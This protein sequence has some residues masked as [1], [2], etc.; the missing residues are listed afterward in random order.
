M[1][2]KPRAKGVVLVLVATEVVGVLVAITTNVASGDLPTSWHAHLWLAWPAL[3]AL[4]LIGILLAIVLH[5]SDDDTDRWFFSK[6]AT[7]SRR[8]LCLTVRKTWVDDFL[9]HSL[10]RQAAIELGL[11]NRSDKLSY[12]WELYVESPGQHPCPLEPGISVTKLMRENCGLLILGEPG[13]GKTTLLLGLLEELLA[14]AEQDEDEIERIPV[15]FKLETWTFS[16]KPLA[17]WLVDE[18]S[19]DQYGVDRYVAERWIAEDQV[20]PLLDGLDEVALD[21]RIACARAIGFFHAAHRSVPLAVTSRIAD[22]DALGLRLALGAAILIRPLTRRQVSEYLDLWGEQLG[23]L[24]TAFRTDPTLWELLKTPFFLSVAVDAYEGIPAADLYTDG[25][26]EDRRT[27]LI[28]TFVERSLTRKPSQQIYEPQDAERWLAYIART[29]GQRLETVFYIEMVDASW[30]PPSPRRAIAFRVSLTS[31]FLSGLMIGLLIDF[32]FSFWSAVCTGILSGLV[33]FRLA[34]SVGLGT[35]G[36]VVQSR[37]GNRFNLL[38]QRLLYWAIAA[39]IAAILLGVIGGFSGIIVTSIIILIDT[40]APVVSTLVNGGSIGSLAGVLIA[41]LLMAVFGAIG[42]SIEKNPDPRAR[43]TGADIHDAVWISC[44]LAT[45][46]GVPAVSLLGATYGSKGLVIGIIVGLTAGYLY[47][48]SGL[49]S[50]WLIHRR[51]ARAG[52][53][54]PKEATFLDYAVSRMLM[55]KV[56]GGYTFAHRLLLEYFACLKPADRPERKSFESL[57]IVDLRP[58]TLLARA[59]DRV[60]ALK[61]GISA[62]PT[63]KNNILRMLADAGTSLPAA[64]FAAPAWNIAITLEGIFRSQLTNEP[65]SAPWTAK[66]E[67]L[68]DLAAG[69]YRLIMAAEH[70][71][72]SPAAAFRLGELCVFRCVVFS[73]SEDREA[74][75]DEAQDAYRTAAGSDHPKYHRRAAAR[76]ANFNSTDV[77]HSAEPERQFREPAPLLPTLR[78][79]ALPSSS[80]QRD[81]SD[82][83]S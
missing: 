21:Q 71:E 27:Q 55:H 20:L 42:L 62:V 6:Q 16:R 13:A 5:R 83:A 79:L 64:R 46:F 2:S 78:R 24:R 60:E 29:L 70:P 19:G 45:V 47:S 31:G 75:H 8:Y 35:D 58:D 10:H 41:L 44:A 56:G 61:S 36:K 67:D 40:P 7:N 77:A 25:P 22:Y 28:A 3:G 33:I 32:F 18:L 80:D 52:L 34:L 76:L 66:A 43:A 53:A 69:V 65:S 54:P 72:F 37:A 57:P 73:R 38:K 82:N 39:S 63:N 14:A 12:P 68:A 74:W 48:G 1:R 81:L 4:V 11:E 15:V 49:L 50:Y 9:A 51:L 59:R 23:G 30:L 17:E 26:L